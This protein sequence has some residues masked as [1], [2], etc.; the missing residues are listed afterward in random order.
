MMMYYRT[1]FLIFSLLLC[2]VSSSKRNAVEEEEQDILE[3]TVSLYF[4][5]GC[6][7]HIQHEF[8]MAERSILERDDRH[9]TSATGY[10]GGT[11]TGSEGRVCYHNFQGIAD[12]GKLGHGEV[13]HMKLPPNRVKQ[14]AQLYFS[15]FDSDTGDRVDPQD[16]GPEYRSIIGIPEGVNS[17]YVPVIEEA[18]NEMG[19]TLGAGN[20]NDPD[21]LGTKSVYVYDS[22]Q[23][24]FYQ[25]E[26]YMQFRDD[27]QSSPY[28]EDYNR[29]VE[30]ALD[31]G[32]IVGTGCPEK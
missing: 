10:A 28:G 32:R 25:A 3:N 21:T 4:G 8:V 5:V 1:L 6:F 30:E 16:R 19:F 31:D 29:L 14:F 9:L 18:A 26:V 24:P 11:K 27:F 12:Y 20:G 23:F 17:L 2:R 15:L 22:L 7:W 13:V